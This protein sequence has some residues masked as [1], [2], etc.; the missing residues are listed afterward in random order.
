[1]PTATSTTPAQPAQNGGSANQPVAL[2]DADESDRARIEAQPGDRRARDDA[3]GHETEQH[4]ARDETRGPG[5]D[6]GGGELE[7]RVRD[8]CAGNE[9][10]DRRA[11]R[12]QR[13]LTQIEEVSGDAD[14]AG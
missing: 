3:G 6:V 1:M 14:E 9:D 7:Q 13:H 11:D 10:G 12:E 5:D 4:D 2:V 8:E